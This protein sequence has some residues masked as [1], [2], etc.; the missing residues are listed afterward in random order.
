MNIKLLLACAIS[1]LSIACTDQLS[2]VE[3]STSILSLNTPDSN[4]QAIPPDKTKKESPRNTRPSIFGDLLAKLNLS[5]EQKKAVEPLLANHKKC[6]MECSNI[7]K[8]AERQILINAKI[9]EDSIKAK[10]K[11]GELTRD[12]A[13]KQLRLLKDQVNQDLKS[14]IIKTKVKECVTTCDNV[15]ILEL[16]SLLNPDQLILVEKWQSQKNKRG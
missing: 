12:E 2:P 5:V 3:P 4:I 10:L 14:I 6:I 15:F 13:M 8:Q 9:K 16:K 7:L 11:S 1:L